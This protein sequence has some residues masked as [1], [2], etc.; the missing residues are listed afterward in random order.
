MSDSPAVAVRQQKIRKEHEEKLLLMK[1]FY[2]SEAMCAHHYIGYCLDY[3][4]RIRGREVAEGFGW[5]SE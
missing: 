4:P 5:G 3:V 2:P 1:V